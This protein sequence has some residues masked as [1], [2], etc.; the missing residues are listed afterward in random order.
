MSNTK[1]LWNEIRG[2][3]SLISVRNGGNLTITG[4]GT[5]KAKENDCFTL[6]VQNGSILTIENGIFI[7]NADAVYVTEGTASIKGGSYSL[8]QKC[9]PDAPYPYRFVLNC[10]DANYKNGSAKI[11]VTGGTFVNFNPANCQAEGNGTNF[12]KD[13]CTVTSKGKGEDTL[14]TVTVVK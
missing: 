10:L 8:Q 2:N 9:P 6:D 1:D 12:V 4:E 11:I 7:S 14:Y 5:F 13:G 3:W